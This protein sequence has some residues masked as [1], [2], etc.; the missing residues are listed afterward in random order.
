MERDGIP[1]APARSSN[2]LVHLGRFPVARSGPLLLVLCLLACLP[3]LGSAATQRR[4]PASTAPLGGVDISA[5]SY[6]SL[7]SRI[8]R[9]VAEAHALHATVVRTEVPWSLLQPLGPGQIDAAALAVTDRLVND[10][11]ADGMRVVMLVAST[12]CAAASRMRP[13]ACERCAVVAADRNRE[14]CC[15]RRLP[16][17]AL[18]YAPSRDRNLERAR[19]SERKVLRRAPQSR[20]L[21]GD[22]AGGVSGDQAGEQSCRRA[23]RLA[24]WLQR[25][26]PASTVRRRHKGLLRRARRTFLHACARLAAR[27]P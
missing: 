24:R 10:A 15:L 13:A 25:P 18:R 17:A 22:S 20:T 21:R 11:A 23:C 9:E 2:M 12:P 7:P 16:G 26:V 3:A 27:D 6:H 4:H 19:S 8:D 1:R 5:P 14:L